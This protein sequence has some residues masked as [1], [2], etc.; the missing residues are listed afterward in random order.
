MS[1]RIGS[2]TTTA[3]TLANRTVTEIADNAGSEI[4]FRGGYNEHASASIYVGFGPAADLETSIDIAEAGD[5]KWTVSGS[6]TNEYYLQID[7]G[8]TPGLQSPDWVEEDGTAYTIGTIGSLA[9]SEWAFGDNDTLGYN[10]LYVRLSSG[11]ADVDPA[12]VANVA[13]TLEHIMVRSSMIEWQAGQPWQN[14]V[15]ELF[16]LPWHAF[17]ITG[18]TLTTDSIK[19]LE[20]K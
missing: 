17:Q 14:N 11:A 3:F 12:N 18:S 1:N 10:T 13:M 4:R 8:G 19:V 15:L 20:G 16:V 5:Y 6:G 9:V 2:V 7:A